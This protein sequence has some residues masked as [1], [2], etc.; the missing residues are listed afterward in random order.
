MTMKITHHYD[1]NDPRMQEFIHE[2]NQNTVI[3]DTTGLE[4]TLDR[5][6]MDTYEF[7]QSSVPAEKI[8]SRQ[9]FDMER[10]LS[11][12]GQ[13]INKNLGHLGKEIHSL[14]RHMDSLTSSQVHLLEMIKEMKLALE[15]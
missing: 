6:A 14:T 7:V 3:L 11:A 9:I 1:G 13:E 12:Q 15:T 5:I 10:R 8:D 4:A 2:M